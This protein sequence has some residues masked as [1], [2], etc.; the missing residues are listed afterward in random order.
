MPNATG[1]ASGDIFVYDIIL[2]NIGDLGAIA[3]NI[4][5]TEVLPTPLTIDTSYPITGLDISDDKFA[6]PSA[7]GL[8]ATIIN[9]NSFNFSISAYRGTK[10]R[11]RFKGRTD[12]GLKV[13][14][15]YITTAT[16][17]YTATSLVGPLT[18]SDIFQIQSP[19]PSS[20]ICLTTRYPVP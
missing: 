18:C 3:T 16:Y 7:N 4:N 12:A 19:D 13:G 14:N 17:S 8:T 1:G 10:Y 9:A 5:L 11:I 6:D 15:E 2:E 20:F